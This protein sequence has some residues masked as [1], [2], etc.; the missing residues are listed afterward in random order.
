M[1]T[2][3][4]GLSSYLNEMAQMTSRHEPPIIHQ[5]QQQQQR[6]TSSMEMSYQQSNINSHDNNSPSCNNRGSY[7]P[8]SSLAAAKLP[9]DSHANN[10]NKSQ[11]SYSNQYSP[12]LDPNLVFD[13]KLGEMRHRKKRG[14]PKRNS[15]S[16]PQSS[17]SLNNLLFNQSSM[18][19]RTIPQ[20]SISSMYDCSSSSPTTTLTQ[21]LHCIDDDVDDEDDRFEFESPPPS[22][23]VQPKLQPLTSGNDELNLSAS[24]LSN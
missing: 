16:S 10:N 19:D 18:V 8:L 4:D 5:Q 1:E 9:Y 11:G 22:S 15:T 24:F 14:R 20:S 13:P 3:V 6:S 23:L 7:N 21:N 2:R 12:L 17:S